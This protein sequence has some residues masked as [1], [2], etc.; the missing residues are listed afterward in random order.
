MIETVWPRAGVAREIVLVL[1]GALLIALAAQIRIA[2]PF[3]P[4]PVTG[5]TFAV[6]LLGALYGRTRGVAT[7]L[8]YLG[9]GAVGFPVFAGGAAGAARLVG[10]TAGYLAGFVAAA[11]V[12]GALAERGWDRRPWTTAAAMVVG[13]LVIYAAGVV[14]LSRFVGWDKVLATGVLPFLAGDAAKIVLATA[15]LPVGWKVVRRSVGGNPGDNGGRTGA[16]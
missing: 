13:S 2:L 1:G 10:P 6:L 4:V 14:W 12:V 5:Q 9:L 11:F 7:V 8:A 3:S 16:P 15:L